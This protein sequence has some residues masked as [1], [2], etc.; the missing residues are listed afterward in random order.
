[1]S[2]DIIKEY[3]EMKWKNGK[4]ITEEIAIYPKNATIN[5]FEWRISSAKF[6]SSGPFS[7]FEGYKRILVQ[8]EG[9]PIKIKHKDSE[10]ILKLFEPYHFS[11][12]IDTDSEVDGFVKDFNIIWK[13]NEY[14]VD[15]KLI[16][17]EEFMN[18]SLDGQENFLFCCKNE[19]VIG[20][21]KVEKFQT[22]KIGKS[23]VDISGK[24]SILLQVSIDKNL[25]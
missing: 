14:K 25:K 13:E 22:I 3:K 11:G 8:L 5:D 19:F 23:K 24:C 21:E 18:I 4:G 9:N 2:C 10:K 7:K 6:D 12:S 16:Q 1:M 20:N 17:I 15:V